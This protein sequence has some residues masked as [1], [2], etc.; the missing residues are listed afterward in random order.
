MKRTPSLLSIAILLG[1]WL[2]PPAAA[3]DLIGPDLLIPVAGRMPGAFQSLWVTDLF[4][5]NTSREPISEPILVVFR[6]DGIPDQVFQT[7]IAGRATVVLRDVVL[8]TFGQGS[9]IGTLRVISSSATAALS[10]RAR[11]Y[12][13]G[14]AVGEYGQTVPGVPVGRLP[15]EAYLSGLSGVGANRTNVGIVNA[16]SEEAQ[17]ILTLWS[18]DGEM[19]RGILVTI[20]PNDLLS[21][22]D[23]FTHLG[24]GP[25]SDATLHVLAS[26]RVYAY[27][28]IVRSD[29]GDADF[30]MASG[31]DR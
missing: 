29:S 24:T 31:T 2:A 10:A 25:L 26:Q 14:S 20:S 30:V 5:T 6:R 19:L 8:Q 16:G 12:N 18:R 23:I 15:R 22:N 7:N 1:I 13:L 9:A 3:S 28:S 11:I 17:V 21:L 4:V 27:A